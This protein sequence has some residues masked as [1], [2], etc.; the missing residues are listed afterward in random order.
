MKK[1]KLEMEGWVGAKTFFD[2]TDFFLF[3]PAQLF[4]SCL[5]Y[6]YSQLSGINPTPRL[7]ETES[8]MER[9]TK[10]NFESENTLT[11]VEI[12]LKSL[13]ELK[14]LMALN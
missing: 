11:S 8:E 14:H 7:L 13:E 9:K 2:Q 1:Q 10:R 6:H 5:V 4:L 3:F 12:Q